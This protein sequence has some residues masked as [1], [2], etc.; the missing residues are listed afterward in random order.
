MSKKMIKPNWDNFKSKFEGRNQQDQF[1]WFCYLLFCREFNQ[2]FGIFRYK[3]QAG[4]ETNPI[5]VGSDVIGFQAK[6]Y[7]TTLSDHKTKLKEAIEKAKKRY[8]NIN[9]IRFY[10]NQEWGQGQKQNDSED[11]QEIETEAKNNSITVEWKCASFFESEFVCIDN[12]IIAKYFFSLDNGIFDVIEKLNSHSESILNESRPQ[13]EFNNNIIEIPIDNYLSRIKIENNK[14]LILSGVGGIGKTA[15]INQFYEQIKK[16]DDAVC[17]V[18]KAIEFNVKRVNEL[19]DGHDLKEFIDVH[20]STNKKIIVIDSAEKLLDIQTDAF[21]LFL[22]QL[23]AENWCVIFTTRD[24]YLDDLHFQFLQIYNT[25]PLNIRLDSLSPD[26]LQNLAE[27]NHFSLPNDSKILDLIRIPFY[28][29]QYLQDYRADESLDFIGFKNKLW[30]I[31]I[32]EK[33]ENHF[34]AIAKQRADERCF[35]IQPNCESQVLEEL[36]KNKIIAYT[37][38][39]YFITHDIYEEWALEKFI[40]KTFINK[41][42]HQQFFTEMGAALPMRRSF[43]KWLSEQLLLKRDTIKTFIEQVIDDNTLAQFW[44]DEI[45]VSIL[46]SDYAVQFFELF[47]DELKDNTLRLIRISFL[48]R[49]A[50]KEI[51]EESLKLFAKTNCDLTHLKLFWTIPKG[52]GWQSFIHY[53]YD[54]LNDIGYEPVKAILPVIY[55]W[56]DKTKRGETTKYSSLIAL[57]YYHYCLEKE[58]YLFDEEKKQLLKTILFGC[59]E[60]KDELQQI[61]ERVLVNKWRNSQDPYC[62]LVEMILHSN[63]FICIRI[64]CAI[65]PLSVLKLAELFWT[66]DSK[67]EDS[68][69]HG[70]EQYFNLERRYSRYSTVSAYKTPIYWLLQSSFKETINFILSFVNNAVEFYSK[71]AKYECVEEVTL[72]ITDEININQFH[73]NSLWC[74][75]RGVSSPV[76]PY[77]LQSIH[78]AL[79]KFFLEDLKEIDAQ[80][81]EYWLIYLLRYSRS[82]S[83]TAIVSSIVLA[84]PEKTFNVALILFKTKAFFFADTHRIPQESTAK[85]L[86][87]IGYGWDYKNKFFQDERL[88]TCEDKHRENYLERLFLQYQLFFDETSINET[89][90]EQRQKTLWDLLDN[91]YAEPLDNSEQ[92]KTWRLFLARMDGRK[93]D[94]VSKE[95]EQGIEIHLISQLEPELKE[96]CEEFQQEMSEEHKYLKLRLWSNYR[97]NRDNKYQEYSDYENNPVMVFEQIKELITNKIHLENFLNKG[98]PAIV[99]AVLIKDFFDNLSEEQTIFCKDILLQYIIPVVRGEYDIQF[100]IGIESAFSVLSV[101]LEKFDNKETIKLILLL[102]LFDEHLISELSKFNASPITQINQLWQNNIE[103]VHSLLIGYLLLANRYVALIHT[104]R[105]ENYKRNNYNLTKT[106][107]ITRFCQENEADLDRIINNQVSFDDVGNIHAI[108]L[109]TLTIAFQLI[110]NDTKQTELK[111]LALK[112]INAVAERLCTEK[113]DSQENGEGYM[114]KHDLTEKFASFVLHSNKKDIE[115]YL[116]PIKINI[117]STKKLD[118]N[119]IT[120]LFEAFISVEK[121][122]KS[123]DN[124]WQVWKLFKPTIIELSKQGDYY[125][126][127]ILEGYLFARIY[128]NEKAVEWHTFKEKDKRFFKSITEE[129]KDSPAVL[130]SVAKLLNNVGS[131]YLNDGIAWLSAMLRDNEQAFKK[132]ENDTVYYL[133]LITQKYIYHQKEEIRKNRQSKDELLVILNFLVNNGSVTAYML[134]E[135]VL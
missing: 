133:E 23:L 85:S 100:G 17:Y 80:I 112:I 49:L 90:F 65:L 28:L 86:Y 26:V 126:S 64:V 41:L 5:T 52:Q 68:Y 83:I 9:K 3:N 13:I 30:K 117:L 12:A 42:N 129:M 73:S 76:M 61:F 110:P 66:A 10:T 94:I 32:T 78:M 91:Y 119:A 11:K 102:S 27:N 7:E 18:F 1:E 59:Y 123:Y 43:R 113:R 35:Y 19:L 114:V 62:D 69:S 6:F 46:L 14:A 97:L 135:E 34:L 51:D 50:C 95:T 25:Q 40:N 87:S 60:I 122:I 75:Y 115:N 96:Y 33:T 31:A 88:K 121:N 20:Q 79:E 24:N 48:L 116:A 81:L 53:V 67:S 93:L 107:V 92:G 99:S 104:I 56:N 47:E 22:S 105:T 71:N 103:E 29:N 84:Y 72:F 106:E 101:L 132:L 125:V 2:P 74:I 16:E 36:K 37:T 77:L 21:K 15:V 45:L 70:V 98:V 111:Q 44:H 89:A 131:C 82:S 109:S 54:N 134:R 120:N 128:W 4:I 38:A 8:P 39:G 63:E 58:V 130:Y 124:F 57:E 108:R 55:E 118:K 127:D